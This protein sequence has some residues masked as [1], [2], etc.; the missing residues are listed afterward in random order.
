M[1]S[2]FSSSVS[3]IIMSVWSSWLPF[4]TKEIE[5]FSIEIYVIIIVNR[6]ITT[7]INV[8]FCF[9][10]P[11][12]QKTLMTSRL[13]LGNL[14]NRSIKI[15]NVINA[16]EYKGQR[17]LNKSRN[18]CKSWNGISTRQSHMLT[19]WYLANKCVIS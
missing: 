6:I 5:L 12:R 11:F 4:Y 17:T 14:F 18:L 19:D 9:Q 1:T 2:N 10:A 13:K 8:P 3:I 16:Y 15:C 7:M